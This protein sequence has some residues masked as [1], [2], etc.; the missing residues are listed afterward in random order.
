MYNI[1]FLLKQYQQKHVHARNLKVLEYQTA[2]C[3]CWEM[4]I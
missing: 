1:S 2:Y 4:L 3:E